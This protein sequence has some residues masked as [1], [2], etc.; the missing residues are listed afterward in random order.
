[1]KYEEVK[2]F[3]EIVD[4]FLAPEQEEYLFNKVKFLP[5]DAIIVKIGSFK[6][7]S[8][9][10][11]AYACLGSNKRIYCIDIWS[12]DNWEKNSSDCQESDFFKIWLKNTSHN[13]ISEHLTPLRGYPHDILSQWCEIVGKK[14]IDFVFIDSSHESKNVLKDFELCFPLIKDGG[15]IA[16]HDGTSEGEGADHVWNELAKIY[17]SNHE[18]CSTI[19]CGQK[20]FSFNTEKSEQSL[21]R[22]LVQSGMTVFDVGANIGDYSIL[23]SK[24]VG[25]SGKVYAFEPT[26]STFKKLSERIEKYQCENVSPLQVAIFSQDGKVEINEFPEDYSAWNSIGQPMMLDPNQNYEKYVEIV[27]TETVESLESSKFWKMRQTWVKLKK[28]FGL[29]ISE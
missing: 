9:L 10:S 15:W 23:F 19:A 27:R 28:V 7:R 3:I 12:A 2:Q 13:G 20:I 6:S 18:Y 29:P 11:M 22:N 8:V 17:L 5:D 25:K 26:I 16:F 1:M 21:V 24:L 14:E 4:G